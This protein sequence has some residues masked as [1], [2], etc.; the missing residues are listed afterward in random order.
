[1]KIAYFQ[2]Y[3]YTHKVL[4]YVHVP[5][6]VTDEIHVTNGV[7]PLHIHVPYLLSPFNSDTGKKHNFL[8]INDL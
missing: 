2:L 6:S 8:K 3:L 7:K 1:M 4:K 5:L